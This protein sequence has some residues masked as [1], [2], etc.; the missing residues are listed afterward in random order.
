MPDFLP[1]RDRDFLAF[2][3]N[4]NTQIGEDPASFGLSVEDAQAYADAFNSFADVYAQTRSNSARTPMSI[5]LKDESRA[6]LTQLTRELARIVRAARGVTDAKR[7]SL[8]LGAAGPSRR[9]VPAP[10][11]SPVVWLTAMDSN[12]VYVRLNDSVEKDRSGKPTDVASAMIYTAVGDAFPTDAAAWRF[13]MSTARTRFTIEFNAEN[14]PGTRV[15]VVACWV[16]ARQQQGP[17]GKAVSLR[18][19]FG[20]VQTRQ[21]LRVAA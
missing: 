6:S 7:M 8:G 4:F 21:N 3:L 15:W 19:A 14:A 17:M 20:G 5:M 16:N 11:S 12:R 9:A 1:R 18:L 2:A 13:Q 10:T